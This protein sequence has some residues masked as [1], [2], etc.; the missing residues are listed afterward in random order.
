MLKQ[1]TTMPRSAERR[2]A[3]WW[4]LLNCWVWPPDLDGMPATGDRRQAIRG[5]FAVVDALA[6]P[7]LVDEIWQNEDRRLALVDAARAE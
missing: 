6:S 5:A 1:E 3:E 7:V 4:V 2:L